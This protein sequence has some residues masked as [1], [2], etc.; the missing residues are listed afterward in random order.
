LIWKFFDYFGF[1][2]AP[3]IYQPEMEKTPLAE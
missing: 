3:G 1:I 2:E